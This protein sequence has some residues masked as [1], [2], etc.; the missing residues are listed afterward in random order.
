MRIGISEG[1]E[2]FLEL[3]PLPLLCLP[4][5]IDMEEE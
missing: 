2:Y 3:S 4:P 1:T 5:N